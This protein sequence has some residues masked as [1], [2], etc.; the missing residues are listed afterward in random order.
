[1]KEGGNTAT[2]TSVTWSGDWMICYKMTR[3]KQSETLLEMWILQQ[4]HQHYNKIGKPI[5]FLQFVTAHV[6]WELSPVD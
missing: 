5:E 6:A 3:G 1:M 2:M 4:L